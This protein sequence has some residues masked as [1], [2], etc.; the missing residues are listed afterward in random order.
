MDDSPAPPTPPNPRGSRRPAPR[1]LPTTLAWLVG[2][3]AAL[4]LAAL[5]ALRWGISHY[6]SSG[7]FVGQLERTLDQSLGAHCR[8]D[9]LSWQDPAIYAASFSAQGSDGAPFRSGALSDLRAEVDSGAL[10]DR[11]W[12]VRH[13]KVAQMSLD[14]SPAPPRPAGVLPGLHAGSKGCSPGAV[15]VDAAPYECASVQPNNQQGCTPAKCSGCP[16]GWTWTRDGANAVVCGK[17]NAQGCPSQRVMIPKAYGE[18]QSAPDACLEAS[19]AWL[20]GG[21]ATSYV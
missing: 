3:A 13:V 5:I 12:K 14:F 21:R 19:P 17:V 2:T 4:A 9:G 8:L 1:R 11:V 18:F 10:W 7:A 16:V 6:L 20:A 15:V